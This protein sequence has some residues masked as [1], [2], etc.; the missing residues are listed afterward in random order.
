MLIGG[1]KQMIVFNDLET[2]EK[3]KIYD[4]GFTS[5]S[6]PK[7]KNKILTDYRI[8]DINIPKI[9]NIEGLAVMTQDF[10]NCVSNNKTPISNNEISLEVIRILEAAEKSMKNDGKMINLR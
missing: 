9:S 4:R 3:V 1:N 7:N 5:P 10:V 6:D 2:T 8:G